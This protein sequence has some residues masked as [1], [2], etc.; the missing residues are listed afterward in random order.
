MKHFI[1]AAIILVSSFLTAPARAQSTLGLTPAALQ[2]LY[3]GTPNLGAWQ[4][5]TTGSGQPYVQFV[6]R[7]NNLVVVSY[8]TAAAAPAEARVTT[9]AVSGPVVPFL[10]IFVNKCDSLYPSES[11]NAWTDPVNHLR[12][13]VEAR[14][15][16]A[17]MRFT[18]LP[19]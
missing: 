4:Q 17:T 7:Q 5:G 15:D 1:P 11:A 19:E 13:T 18:A 16:V 10:G 2:A 9:T 8:F 6:D 14:A 12:I 3:R